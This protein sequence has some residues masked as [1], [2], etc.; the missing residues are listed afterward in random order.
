MRTLALDLETAPALVWTWS[1]WKP[2][3][4]HTQV[5]ESSRILCFSAQW[6]GDRKTQFYSEWGDGRQAML[7]ALYELL[8]EADVVVTYNGKK[9]DVPWIEGELIVAGF[10]PP[11]PYK[12]VDL[13]QVIR[14]HSRFLSNKLD[15]AATRLL[16]DQKVT[17]SGFQL[18]LD[19]MAGDEKAQRLMERYAKK[20]TALLIP[21]Y[22]RLR[23]WI[24]QHPNVA[25]HNDTEG[26][27]KC[28]SD[29]LERRGYATTSVSKFQ[30]YRCRSCGGWSRDATRVG[31]VSSRNA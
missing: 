22:H 21:L 14:S 19:C 10:T 3:I 6:D 23:P 26:C 11:S 9:F 29:D 25:L 2:V 7:Q 15:Y 17:H 27:P 18:W 12:Q 5:K 4:G 16:D 8:D 30:R 20:D 24:S 13:Y 1:L 28:G 31:A